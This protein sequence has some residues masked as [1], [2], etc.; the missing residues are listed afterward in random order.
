[1]GCTTMKLL[2]LTCIALLCGLHTFAQPY[3]YQYSRTITINPTMVSGSSP[4]SN[5]PV[6]IDITSPD[7]RSTASGGHMGTV[8]GW[9]LYFSGSDCTAGYPYEIDSYDPATGHLRVWVQMPSISSTGP[10]ELYMYY[11]ND[12]ISTA[13]SSSSTW[14]SDY[15]GVWHL[16]EQPSGAANTTVYDATAYD[17]DGTSYGSMAAGQQVSGQ[18]GYGWDFDETNDYIRI[19]DFDYT[20][21]FMVSFWFRQTDDNTGTGFQYLYSHNNYGLNHSLNVYF[22]EASTAVVADRNMLKTIFQDANDATNTS[23]LDAGTSLVDG[24]WHYYTLRVLDPSGVR[25][26]VDGVE[27]GFISFDGG[28]PF[29]PPT[30]LYLGARSD[31]SAT[32]YYGGALDEVRVTNDP[33]TPD[34]VRTEYNNQLNPTAYLTLGSEVSA[35]TNCGVLPIPEGLTLQATA[36][37]VGAL[38]S[39]VPADISSG[40]YFVLERSND[41]SRWGTVHQQVA[42]IAKSDAYTWVDQSLSTTTTNYYRVW[43]HTA[44]GSSTLSNVVS[45]ELPILSLQALYPN[46][47]QD[48]L[49]LLLL[50]GKEQNVQLVVMDAT[51]RQ[52]MLQARLLPAGVH[53]VQLPVH[54]LATGLYTLIIKTDQEA[55][56]HI[57]RPFVVN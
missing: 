20:Q 51:G 27:R 11:G 12:T 50:C 39:W 3:G 56:P 9:D 55:A 7:L 32:R 41:M 29:D 21:T 49:Q 6:L 8:E 5:F 46:P 10:N 40:D 4:L 19:P 43:Q 16:N 35:E 57:Y 34:W 38:L 48:Q 24:N 1:M 28:N 45:L 2:Y 15:Q 36:Q 44:T 14:T 23:D 30:D 22:G 31:L 37:A 18:V 17:R 26:Y 42:A 52:C 33:K 47:V 53:Q 54:M 25:V 13:G